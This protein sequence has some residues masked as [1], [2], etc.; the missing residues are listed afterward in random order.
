MTLSFR[1]AYVSPLCHTPTRTCASCFYGYHIN[2]TAAT[3]EP[4]GCEDANCNSCVPQKDRTSATNCQTCIA[5]YYTDGAPLCKAWGCDTTEDGAGCK[6][7]AE[8]SSRVSATTC[9]SC[10]GGFCL[11]GSNC[12]V[13]FAITGPSTS[14]GAQTPGNNMT[15]QWTSAPCASATPGGEVEVAIDICGPVASNGTFKSCVNAKKSSAFSVIVKMQE[16]KETNTKGR[17]LAA[18]GN[19]GSLILT[20]L[21]LP[22]TGPGMYK[23]RVSSSLDSG[24]YSFSSLFEIEP[25]SE[26]V[27]QASGTL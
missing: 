27:S 7:C 18:V 12:D 17:R 14:D 4:W 6:S 5:G 11:Q 16:S 23:I 21:T 22:P 15:V 8:R 26:P 20:M 13:A 10:H 25:T 9:G 19:T 24:T 2:K 1:S 3:C